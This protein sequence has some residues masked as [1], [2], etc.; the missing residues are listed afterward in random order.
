M[1]RAYPVRRGYDIRPPA[2]AGKSNQGSAPV[3]PNAGRGL[4]SSR[5]NPFASAAARLGTR[6]AGQGRRCLRYCGG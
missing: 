3:Q 4:D 5:E 1:I 6:A 2:P